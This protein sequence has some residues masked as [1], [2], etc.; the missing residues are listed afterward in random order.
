MSEFL[1]ID[2]IESWLQIAYFISGVLLAAVALYGTVQVKLLKKSIKISSQHATWQKAV[3]FSDRYLINNRILLNKFIKKCK[4]DG[5]PYAYKGSIGNFRPGEISEKYKETHKKRKSYY[6]LWIPI[7]N[8]LQVIASAFISGVADERIGFEFI[9]RSYCNDVITL[10]DLISESNI[11]RTINYYDNIIKLFEIWIIRIHKM[12]NE[13]QKA[14][15]TTKN[16]Q[17]KEMVKVLELKYRAI[18]DD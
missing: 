3:E 5:I 1:S 15:L 9:G 7:L 18:G 12:A 13:Q 16:E 14:Y 8:D 11:Y 10:Y 4:D 2:K 17:I 6:D